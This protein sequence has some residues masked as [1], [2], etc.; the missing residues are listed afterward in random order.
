M[1]ARY[2]LPEALGGGVMEEYR[3]VSGGGSEAP[4]GTVA[5]LLDGCLMCLARGLLTEV[6]PPLPEEPPAGFYRATDGTDGKTLA[7]RDG[8]DWYVGGCGGPLPW[9]AVGSNYDTFVRL[10]AD[11]FAEPVELP[12]ELP[13]YGDTLTVAVQGIGVGFGFDQMMG[14]LTVGDARLAARALWAAADAAERAS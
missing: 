11:P 6:P 13:V 1:S 5:F 12:W 10:V 7:E 2:R 8:D 4:V 3:H 9:D 14:R